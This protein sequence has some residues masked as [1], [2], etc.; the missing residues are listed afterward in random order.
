MPLHFLEPDWTRNPSLQRF[1]FATGVECSTPT[2][3]GPNG[4]SRRID[5]LDKTR[6]YENWRLDLALVVDLGARALRYGL[7]WYRVHL[8]PGRFDWEFPDQ[9]MR[10]IRDLQIHPIVDLCHF[11]VP[12]WVGD[13]QNPDLPRHFA[14]YAGAVSSRYPWVR[15]FTP[16]NEMYICAQ[17][18]AYE[19]WW[20]ERLK[21]HRAFV[22]A[23]K[24]M[25]R[26]SIE[27]MRAIL[28]SRA[29]ALFVLCESSERTHARGPDHVAEADMYNSRRFLSLDLLCGR[30]MSSEMYRYVRDNGMTE[31][32]YAYFLRQ[33]LT[34]HFILGQDYYAK[35]EWLVDDQ[36]RRGVSGDVFGYYP[37]ALQYARR[38]R[39][40]IMHTETNSPHDPVSWLWRTWSNI[41]LLRNDGVPLLGMTWYSLTHQVDWDIVLREERDRVYPVGLFDLDRRITPVGVEYQKLIRS[42]RDTPLYPNGP[43]ALAADLPASNESAP[44][45][46]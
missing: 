40:P 12:D 34:E 38:Y 5:Q 18:S 7:P 1:L 27:G 39:L 31:D 29:D 15:W 14:E 21:S 25:A 44:S 6:H 33:R 9:V 17:F 42:W 24:N 19:G 26:A 8:G 28:A 13:F 32:E 41:R 36:G 30:Q 45:E 43:L 23:L 22:T 11:G 35:N 3:A 37:I 4:T 2:I 20:N 16:I 46:P 10:A